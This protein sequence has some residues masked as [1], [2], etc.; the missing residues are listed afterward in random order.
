MSVIAASPE[1]TCL[2]PPR[3]DKGDTVSATDLPPS[4]GPDANLT[5]ASVPADERPSRRFLRAQTARRDR[6]RGKTFS[7]LLHDHIIVGWD[8]YASL[9]RLRL[10]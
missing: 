4:R 1:A 3:Y 8:G 5:A 10:I 6:A 2:A 7:I 9:K